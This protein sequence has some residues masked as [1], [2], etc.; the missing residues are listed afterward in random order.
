MWKWKWKWWEMR[1]KSMF[2][3]CRL[4]STLRGCGVIT[5]EIR[6]NRTVYVRGGGKGLGRAGKIMEIR[7]KRL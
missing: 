1:K 5:Q 7:E 6:K 3:E 4:P 2:I